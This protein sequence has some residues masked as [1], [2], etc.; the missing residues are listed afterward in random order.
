VEGVFHG[1]KYD[2]KERRMETFDAWTMLGNAIY[3]KLRTEGRRLH[4]T[5]APF[6]YIDIYIHFRKTSGARV[7][8]DNREEV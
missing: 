7:P 8:P 2:P 3:T 6:Y 1:K 5:E 4:T